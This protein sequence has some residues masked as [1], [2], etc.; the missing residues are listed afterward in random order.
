M[1]GWE[2]TVKG[3]SRSQEVVVYMTAEWRLRIPQKRTACGEGNTS[4]AGGR[5]PSRATECA[6]GAFEHK[7]EQEK[8]HEEKGGRVKRAPTPCK[9][10]GDTQKKRN[11]TT[12]WRKR[13]RA[14]FPFPS[15]GSVSS[16]FLKSLGCS[17][18]L[19]VRGKGRALGNFLATRVLSL[20]A[21]LYTY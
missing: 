8:D 3:R 20:F 15:A 21:F 1:G 9:S 18:A 12:T 6:H 13:T 7:H 17:C 19:R 2:D 14:S 16:F 5:G 4:R 11:N 10:Q